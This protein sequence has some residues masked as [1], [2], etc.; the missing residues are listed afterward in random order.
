MALLPQSSVGQM[1]RE[2]QTRPPAERQSQ[3][4]QY[5]LSRVCTTININSSPLSAAYVRR[6]IR[7]ALLQIMVCRLIGTKPLSGQTF[8]YSQELSPGPLVY[9]TKHQWNFNQNRKRFIHGNASEYI[10][11][12]M[13]AILSRGGWANWTTIKHAVWPSKCIVNTHV[14][15]DLYQFHWNLLW[16][17]TMTLN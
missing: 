6:W 9:R 12:E 8:R 4:L 1:D 15:I 16:K 17:V 11:C 13:T 14:W 2:I 5:P 10:V 7:S 3:L